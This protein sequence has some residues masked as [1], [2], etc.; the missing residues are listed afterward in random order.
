MMRPMLVA[1]LGAAA[2]AVS[3]PAGA[4]MFNVPA[5]EVRISGVTTSFVR[6][7]NGAPG[8][9]YE[10]LNPGPKAAIALFV[11]HASGDYLNFSACGELAKRGYRVLCANNS[12]D[13]S[14][15]FDDGN[16]DQAL[17]EM[18]AGI[19]WLKTYPGVHKV[20]L[21][22][23]S[24]GATLM[25]AYEMIAEGG[26]ASCQGPE[27]I[28]KCPASLAGLPRA[29]GVVLADANW[30]QAEMVLFSVD[31]AVIDDGDGQKLNPA[32][33]MYN[34]ANGYAKSGSRYSPDFVHRFLAAEGKRNNEVVAKAAARLALID[35]GKGDYLD[36]EPFIVA[37]AS[38]IGNR[39]FSEDTTLLEHSQKPYP[40]IHG[41]GSVTN[42]IIRSLRLS[43]GRDN[44]SRRMSMGAIKTTVR[45]FLSSYAIR[46]KPNFAYDSD[47]IEGVDWTS[48]YAS[49]P[50]DVEGISV[51]LLT[52]GMTGHWE[53]L[54]AETIYDHA[55]SPDRT[56]AFV[57]GATH[58]YTPC[59]RCL[60][61]ASAF[62]DTVKT[63]YDYIDAWLSKPGRF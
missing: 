49:P 8:V 38:F 25:T 10:P 13:K 54:A 51:P 27:K 40:L 29:D 2:L 18:K 55:R 50:G 20:V 16:M 5:G 46:V 37:G 15:T 23:H 44:P 3:V 57:E 39:L 34:P 4:Q 32:L 19:G 11:M 24:G 21:F 6:L 17:L 7:A 36:D 35:A 12:S 42:E 53:G 60:K 48:T 31:P 26:V 52:L 62:G 33:D 45:N 1:L 61:P 47:G 22:G 14:G 41:D 63:T 59:D 56:I 9:L 30:G 58:V 28:H 43:E